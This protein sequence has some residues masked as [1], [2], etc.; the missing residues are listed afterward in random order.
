MTALIKEYDYYKPAVGGNKCVRLLQS[1]AAMRASPSWQI[2]D[3]PSYDSM[4]LYWHSL[5]SSLVHWSP[6]QVRISSSHSNTTPDCSQ[7]DAIHQKLSWYNFSYLKWW[8]LKIHYLSLSEAIEPNA[9]AFAVLSL[10]MII[11]N[12]CQWWVSCY[13][14]KSG[15]NSTDLLFIHLY[16]KHLMS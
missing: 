7:C 2:N 5:K 1:V 15:V 8:S 11:I 6:N 4:C 12:W 13:A 14:F 9:L 16:V 3:L 10:C